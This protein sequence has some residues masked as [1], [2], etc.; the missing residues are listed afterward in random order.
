MKMIKEIVTVLL[1]MVFGCRQAPAEETI[2]GP[3]ET[4]SPEADAL[5]DEHLEKGTIFLCTTAQQFLQKGWSKDYAGL[6][7]KKWRG[8]NYAGIRLALQG[9]PNHTYRIGQKFDCVAVLTNDGEKAQSLNTGGSCGMTHALSLLVISPD[10]GLGLGWC[11]GAVGGP[12]CRCRPTHDRVNPGHSVML[13]TGFATDG[14]VPWTLDKAGVYVVVGTYVVKSD[15]G[16]AQ[17]IYS[18]PLPMT[19]EEE[20]R[21]GSK[22]DPHFK[23]ADHGGAARLK[24]E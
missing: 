15:E 19:V 13:T 18:N 11:R 4:S 5:F 10:G 14:A 23:S 3:L 22:E 24:R 20:E 8:S 21:A 7:R 6:I 17:V 1:V 12:H 9:L 16:E 2:P